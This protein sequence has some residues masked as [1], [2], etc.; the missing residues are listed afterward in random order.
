MNNRFKEVEEIKNKEE[1]L[2]NKGTITNYIPA[3]DITE[4]DKKK[5]EKPKFI[6]IPKK[7]IR[8]MSSPDEKKGKLR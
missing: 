8:T 6:Y 7:E 1:K 3:E 5:L 4:D 2:I